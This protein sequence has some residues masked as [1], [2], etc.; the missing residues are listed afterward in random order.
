MLLAF[1]GAEAQVPAIT[2]F[3][4]AS[5]T[6]GSSV[7][8]TGKAFNTTA[9]QAQ[10]SHRSCATM[11]VLKRQLQ[12]DPLLKQRMDDIESAVGTYVARNGSNNVNSITTIPVVF[13]TYCITHRQKT[14]RMRA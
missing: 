3:A 6:I 5:G 7:T 14:F 13:F 8:I 2:T 1:I 10:H 4:P 11:D 12:N 9:T